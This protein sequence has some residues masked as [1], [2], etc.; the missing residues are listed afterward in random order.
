M[1]GTQAQGWRLSGSLPFVAQHRG[2]PEL[3]LPP[4]GRGWLLC[5]CQLSSALVFPRL[6]SKTEP[7]Q[8]HL[9]HSISFQGPYHGG[10]KQGRP[11]PPPP[12]LTTPGRRWQEVEAKEA[13]W[14]WELR[15]L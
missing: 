14:A 15:S 11:G 7:E 10:S 2:G 8:A 13:G 6:R 3:L 9:R 12:F 1:G 5:F 4:A